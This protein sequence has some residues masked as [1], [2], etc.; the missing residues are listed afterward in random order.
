MSRT[1]DPPS[2]AAA[3]LL[4]AVM[5]AARAGAL[6]LH[7]PVHRGQVDPEYGAALGDALAL[8]LTEL[9]ETDDLRAPEGAI[10]EAQTLAAS[11]FGAARTWFLVGGASAGIAASLLA[12]APGGRVAI[13]RNAHVSAV[14]GLILADAAPVWIPVP[15]DGDWDVAGCAGPAAVAAALAGAPD[16]AAVFVTAPTYFGDPAD[17]VAIR[18]V[19]G[20]RLLV[21]DEAHGA[22]VP[23]ALAAGADLVIHS[24]H[25]GL[26]GP[27]Q[28]G[29]LHLGPGSRIPAEG[30]AAALRLVQSTSPSYWLLAGLDAARREA[31]LRRAGG[32]AAERI[33]RAAAAAGL[34]LRSPA[35]PTRL[36]VR[37]PDGSAAYD[38]LAG[39]GV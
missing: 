11:H 10:A 37:V 28:G 22:H 34:A 5:R 36:L 15:W 29:Y 35:D 1:P 7:T 2:Q 16:V 25:K 26:T 12:A 8:D 20:D 27:T 30:V 14:S 13:A 39:A 24:A 18:A 31:A 32:D 9:A 19:C 3:P 6:R 38:A 4:A 23:R 17:L 33:A 21:V